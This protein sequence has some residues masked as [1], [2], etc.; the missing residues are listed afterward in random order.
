MKIINLGRGQGKTTRLLY[1]S[2]WQGAPILCASYENKKYLI[3][4]AKELGLNIPE[5]VCVSDLFKENG[6]VSKIKDKDILVD[7]A[8]W[9]LR[10]FL[11]N[12]GT[13]S[14]VKAI[15]LTSDELDVMQCEENHNEYID[16]LINDYK[17][18]VNSALG[19]W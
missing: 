10:M 11:K 2:E 9:V 19:L 18:Y 17:K 12:M 5:P 6:A 1:A 16:K 8:P 4:M 3:Y 13:N 15:T 7:E 14:E